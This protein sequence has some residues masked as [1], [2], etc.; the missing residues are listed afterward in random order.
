MNTKTQ[1]PLWIPVVLAA[2]AALLIGVMGMLATDLD[3]W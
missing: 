1:T 3:G 2:A